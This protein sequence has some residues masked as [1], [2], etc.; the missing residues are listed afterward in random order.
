MQERHMWSRI[1]WPAVQQLR[2]QRLQSR[3]SDGQVHKV[4]G[5]DELCIRLAGVAWSH[6]S[7]VAVEHDCVRFMVFHEECVPRH[8]CRVGYSF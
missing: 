4:H 2:P 3:W 1:H 6:A 7:T 5:G 8:K